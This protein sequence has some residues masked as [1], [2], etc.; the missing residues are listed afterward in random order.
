MRVIWSYSSSLRYPP[1]EAPHIK[2]KYIFTYAPRSF[3]SNSKNKWSKTVLIH[4]SGILYSTRVEYYIIIKVTNLQL[5]L[6]AQF[7]T[8]E[9]RQI[10]KEYLNYNSFKKLRIDNINLLFIKS[11]LTFAFLHSL[12]MGFL[13]F[14]EKVINVQIIIQ[15]TS[16]KMCYL[17]LICYHK[18][19]MQKIIWNNHFGMVETQQKETRWE[20]TSFK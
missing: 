5:N 14:L 20:L 17:Y 12:L 7:W 15:A 3:V 13:V 1:S 8:K 11:L 2:A 4:C 6:T 18:Q 10:F 9:A 16:F 19:V